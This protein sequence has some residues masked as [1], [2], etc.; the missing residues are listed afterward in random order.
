VSG[1]GALPSPE[2]RPAVGA[3]VRRGFS[4]CRASAR[5][6]PGRCIV[7]FRLRGFTR[8]VRRIVAAFQDLG[9]IPAGVDDLLVAEYDDDAV[10]LATGFTVPRSVLPFVLEWANAAGGDG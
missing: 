5:P 8:P 6:S 3:A 10:G 2:S 4:R 1:A 9:L 7:R